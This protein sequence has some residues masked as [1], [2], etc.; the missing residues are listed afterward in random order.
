ME[1]WFPVR[2]SMTESC[3]IGNSNVETTL[4]L[5]LTNSI[6]ASAVRAVKPLVRTGRLNDTT[7]SSADA[8]SASSAGWSRIT[9]DCSNPS[10]RA[11][12][13][14]ST[15]GQTSEYV[16]VSSVSVGAAVLRPNA[17]TT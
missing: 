4:P 16:A 8:T 9:K 13:V 6:P 5:A 11:D 15:P 3:A 1:A 7:P 12:T 17:H 10:R 14:T 2:S